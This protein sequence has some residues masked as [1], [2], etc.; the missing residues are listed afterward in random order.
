MFRFLDRRFVPFVPACIFFLTAFSSRAQIATA[1]IVPDATLET[2]SSV[3]L[4]D[5][6][7]KGELAELIEGGAA[8]GNNLF[9]SFSE[10]N[11]ADG[12]RVYFANPT[13]IDAIVSRVTGDSSSY[14]LGSLGVAG[15]ADL[16]FLNPNGLIFGDNAE[17]DITGSFYGTTAEAIAFGNEIFSATDPAASSLLAVSPSVSFW[18]YLT[19]RSGDIVAKGQLISGDD[20]TLAGSSLDL[21]VQIEAAGNLSLLAT[22]TLQIRDTTE[23]PFIA[24]AGQDLLIQG[25]DQVDILAL[26]HPDSGLFSSGDMLLRSAG[27]V[28]GDAHYWSGGNFK[29]EDLVGSAGDL[30]SPD[31]PIIRSQG[32]V[33]FATYEGA[34]LHILAGGAVDIGTVTITSADQTGNAIA[35]ETTP[36]LATVTLSEG[37]VVVVD[38]SA[39]PTVDIRAGVSPAVIGEPLGTVGELSGT[40]F[41][42]A[43][44]PLSPPSNIPTTTSADIT[45]GDIFIDA[46]NGLVLLTN[47]YQPNSAL[48]SGNIS[49]TGNGLYGSGINIRGIED[50][51]GGEAYLNARNDIT[52]TNSVIATTGAGE[53]GDIVI[54][55]NGTVQFDASDGIQRTGA[56]SNLGGAKA[57]GEGGNIRI[58]ARNL[59]LL[60]GAILAASTFGQGNAGDIL[61]SVDETVNF[62]GVSMIL[63]FPNNPGGVFSDVRNTAEG[64]GGTVEISARNLNVLDGARIGTSSFGLGDAG[65]VILNI[66]E[67]ARFEGFDPISQNESGAFSNIQARSQGQGGNIRINARNLQLLEG[68]RLST[69]TFGIGNAGNIILTI[70]DTARF[71]GSVPGRDSTRISG[72][73]SSVSGPGQVM[74]A[75]GNGGNVQITAGNLQV[76]GG[77]RLSTSTFGLGNAGNV[78]LDIEETA[79]FEG[80]VAFI[81]EPQSNNSEDSSIGNR[82]SGAFSRTARRGVG[83]GGNVQVNARNLEVLNGAALSAATFGTG[84]A[85]NVILN[86]EESAQ[87]IGTDPDGSASAAFTSIELDAIGEGGDIE[88]NAANLYISDGGVLSATSQGLGNAGNVVINL[89]NR[90][91]ASNGTISTSAEFSSGGQIQI[92]AA[93]VVL[94]EDSDIQTFVNAGDNSSGNIQVI[95]NT[96]IALDDSDI[97]AFAADGRGGDIDLSQTT[98]FGEDANRA[99]LEND[100]LAFDKNGRTDIN[101]TGGVASGQ[102]AVNDST[103]IENSLSELSGNIVNLD[104]F[105][106]N[107]CVAQRTESD[108]SF[109]IT[110][111]EGLPQQPGTSQSRYPVGDIQTLPNTDNNVAIAEPQAVYQ[112]ADGRLVLGRPCEYVDAAQG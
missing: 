96:L 20:V 47:Q 79:Q 36:E 10:F 59:D 54:V 64:K 69:R 3:V 4:S 57:T 2:E 50:R 80:S 71:E 12:Q 23:T 72:A 35:P 40:F 77:A 109:T 63:G 9:H 100:S 111:R 83:Q 101:A 62:S 82:A 61:I 31:D 67:T 76:L 51:Q 34:S 55:A 73:I 49:V 16:F 43:G 19:D 110:N 68:A 33:S 6:L 32:N 104:R 13:Y 5:V 84:D 30:L 98:Y 85:G 112:L 87:F 21:Q 74:T 92:T 52:F 90:L 25:N 26:S 56:F 53:V 15:S 89:Q 7:I 27:P 103:F 107:R 39:K 18:N 99:V 41:D 29:I 93:D 46:A 81:E 14:I 106:S 102:I 108:R 45:I 44:V 22:D 86:V 95:A 105:V 88:V 60:E 58:Q 94:Q 1:Q 48:A 28:Q 65:N 37:T 70:A 66:Q 11:V 75:E 97:L 24:F 8:R 42:E 78:I 91:E 38:G 17:L